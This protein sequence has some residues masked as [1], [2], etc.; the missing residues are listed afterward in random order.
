MKY[1][2]IFILLIH[3]GLSFSQIWE[4][5]YDTL[6][7]YDRLQKMNPE[8]DVESYSVTSYDSSG[9]VIQFEYNEFDSKGYL[10]KECQGLSSDQKLDT[11]YYFYDEN[12]V[13]QEKVRPWQERKFT[14]REFVKDSLN[15]TI[16]IKVKFNDSISTTHFFYSKTG[17]LDSI[18]YDSDRIR[19]YKYDENNKLKQKL[20]LVNDKLKEYYNYY[21][22]DKNSLTYTNCSLITV[23]DEEIAACDSTIGTYGK[24]GKISQVESYL[25]KE[26]KPHITR[27]KYDRKGKITRIDYVEATGNPSTKYYRN[28]KGLLIKVEH[29][30]DKGNVY[31]YA[32]FKYEY[33]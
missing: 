7:Y 23:W 15:R 30:N 8:L 2:V 1:T 33:K 20:I 31:R 28:R 14:T 21:H 9:N 17:N 29:I 25:Y 12:G 5:P 13:F 27:F 24:N 26:D 16:A 3:S 18:K 11:S 32:D 4:E 10:I 22:P 6:S 19:I